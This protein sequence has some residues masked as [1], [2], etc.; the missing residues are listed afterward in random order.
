V[1]RPTEPTELIYVPNPS[2]A[3]VLVAAAVALLFAG[4]FMGW[5][6]WA[7]GAFVLLIGVRAW[8]TLSSDEISR[9]RRSQRTD[10]AV[11]PAE[12]IQSRSR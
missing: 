10:T 7:L 6:L 12:P 9:M 11:I 3:P 1:Q 5:F 4:T 2:W 8:W